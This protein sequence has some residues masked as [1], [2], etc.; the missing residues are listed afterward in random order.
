MPPATLRGSARPGSWQDP[1]ERP[2]LGARVH[3][4]F[5][6]GVGIGPGARLV[7][8]VELGN[9]DAAAETGRTRIFGVDG[10]ARARHQQSPRGRKFLQTRQMRRP[11]LLPC[12]QCV[13]PVIPL[14]YVPHTPP[15]PRLEDQRAD[16]SR[17]GA[18]HRPRAR[19]TLGT[20][21]HAT[22]RSG[23]S[24]QAQRSSRRPIRCP[25]P[26]R[27]DDLLAVPSPHATR[28]LLACGLAYVD[29]WDRAGTGTTL[30]AITQGKAL[31]A[32]L[33]PPPATVRPMST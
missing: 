18:G 17:V 33:R 12:R 11:R 27:V 30:I 13:G 26:A 14:D 4:R 5:H 9:H 22:G 10:R 20:T 21:A 1:A 32:R 24:A 3:T 29:L 8:S 6:I 15:R 28:R 31:Q 2:D 19:I 7:Q 16:S 23:P 25:P